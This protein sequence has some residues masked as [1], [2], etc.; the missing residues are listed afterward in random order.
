MAYKGGQSFL[1][2]LAPGFLSDRRDYTGI[3]ITDRPGKVLQEISQTGYGGFFE[4][5]HP[6]RSGMCWS[7]DGNS[8]AFVTK[9][10]ATR[11]GSST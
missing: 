11:C 3:M 9:T 8:L 2:F 4:S 7:P 1:L 10:A 5:F 6:F